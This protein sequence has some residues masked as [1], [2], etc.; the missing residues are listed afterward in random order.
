M[1]E[2]TTKL[3]KKLKAQRTAKR[4]SLE[5]LA[6][7]S[8][9]S[10]AML[11]QIEQNKVNPTVAVMLKITDALQVNLS[12]IVENTKRSHIL[13][14]IPAEDQHYTYRAD[15]FCTIRTTS[16]I[17]LEKNIE[18]Y[19]VTLEAQGELVSEPHYP[20]TEE[21]LHLNQGKLSVISGDETINLAKGD[22]IHYRAD[23]NHVLKN[24]GK[25]RVEAYLVVWYKNE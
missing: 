6:K 7:T 9:V 1:T 25:G 10:K 21:F 24:I 4:L 17:S 14:V 8:G 12:E 16:P 15:K 13:R 18:I 20:G 5:Q 2:A 23:V 11:S 22:S 3:A 19:R